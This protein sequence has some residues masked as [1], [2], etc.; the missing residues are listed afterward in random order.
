MT[1]GPTALG[2]GDVTAQ[3]ANGCLACTGPLPA[4]RVRRYCSDR[5]RQAG[6]R[7]RNQ[8]QASSATTLPEPT[9]RRT[10]TIYVCPECDTRYL[11]QNRCA[12]CN[13][14]CQRLGPGGTCHGCDELITMEELM[15]TTP[16]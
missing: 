9:S 12:D 10:G 15:R 2:N 8:T 13:T 14:F 11:G 5:C 16:T 4:G 3:L 7:R 6:W 1:S